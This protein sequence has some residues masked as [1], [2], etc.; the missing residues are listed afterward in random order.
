[1]YE[2]TENKIIIIIGLIIVIGVAFLSWRTNGNFK[3]ETLSPEEAGTRTLNYINDNFLPEGNKATLKGEVEEEKGL[4][5]IKLEIDGQEQETYVTKDGEIIFPTA[6]KATSTNAEDDSNSDSPQGEAEEIPKAEKPRVDLYV[7]SFCPFG[8][9]AEDTMEEAYNLLKDKIDFNVHYIVNENNG[10]ISSL[11]GQKE[12]DQNMREV[13]VEKNYGMDKWWDFTTYVNENC[14]EIGDCWED[15]AQAAN[16]SVNTIQ[17]CVDEEGKEL[18]IENAK[19]SSEN[20]V[21]GSPTM[22]INGVETNSVYNYGQPNSYKE[23]ICSAFENENDQCATELESLEGD[24]SDGG[25][26]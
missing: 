24:S 8:N 16:L 2:K 7:M 22:L 11:H 25:S 17:N 19:I 10:E 5:R 4:Y 15:S 26:C 23:A 1:M 20:N 3:T 6:I 14:G 13:C 21:S 12:V 18:M 9:Q